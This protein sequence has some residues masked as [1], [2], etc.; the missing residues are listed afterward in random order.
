MRSR[1]SQ[2]HKCNDELWKEGFDSYEDY[3]FNKNDVVVTSM[4]YNI[5]L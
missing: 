5:D 2:I 1:K 4:F 3:Q